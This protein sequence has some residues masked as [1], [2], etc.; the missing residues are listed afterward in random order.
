MAALHLIFANRYKSIFLLH[1][2]QIQTLFEKLFY[3]SVVY[4]DEL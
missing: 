3:Q 4:S 1:Y 2:L